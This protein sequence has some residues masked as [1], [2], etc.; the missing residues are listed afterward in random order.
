MLNQ[1][2]LVGR[3]IKLPEVKKENNK[4]ILELTIAVPRNYKNDEGIYETDFLNCIL[5]NDVAL[6]TKQFC[7]I[8]NI[9]GIKGR[10]QNINNIPIVMAEKVTFLAPNKE[11]E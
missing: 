8:G 9:V 1:A 7:N 5:Y 3:V 4:N 10:L 6:N 11:N 2:I